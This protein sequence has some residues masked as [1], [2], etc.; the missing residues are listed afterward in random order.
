MK[1]WEFLIP[2]VLILTGLACL[3]MSGTFMFYQEVETYFK[4]FATLCFWMSIPIVAGI[5]LY[6]I[7]FKKRS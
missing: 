6:L 1:K 2:L 3:T 4:T 7:Y 5:I